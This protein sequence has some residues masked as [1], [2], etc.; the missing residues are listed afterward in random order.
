M[1][2]LQFLVQNIFWILPILFVILILL[3]AYKANSAF[4]KYLEMREKYSKMPTSLNLT[5]QSLGEEFSRQYFNHIIK[6]DK[7]EKNG[8]DG[9]YNPSAKTVALKEEFLSTSTIASISV[10]AHEFGH[11]VQH[12]QNPQILIKHQKLNSFVKVLGNLNPLLVILSTVLCITLSYI[13]AL[14]GVAII[15]LN[16]IVAICLKAQTTLVEKD[17]SNEAL[18]LLQNYGVQQH[19]LVHIKKFLS[20]AKNTYKADL[21]CAMLGWTGLTRKTNYF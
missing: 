9:S 18:K 2:I 7:V 21:V 20:Y 17:A 16:T 10:L 11:A 1:Q 3:L 13:Y 8:P 19:D 4:D 5:A 15:A 12:F 6:I 14:I